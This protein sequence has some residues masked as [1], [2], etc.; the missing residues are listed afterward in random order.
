MDPYIRRLA[1]APIAPKSLLYTS[2]RW[3]ARLSLLFIKVTHRYRSR[4]DEP[5]ENSETQDQLHRRTEEVIDL[6]EVVNFEEADHGEGFGNAE[7]GVTDVGK[8]MSE[9]V[10]IDEWPLD[11]LGLFGGCKGEDQ[12]LALTQISGCKHRDQFQ[13]KDLEILCCNGCGL[14]LKPTVLS[15]DPYSEIHARGESAVS[16][17][18][19]LNFDIKSG[20]YV[21]ARF[22]VDR[23]YLVRVLR[24]NPGSFTDFLSGDFDVVDLATRP[25]YD[26]VS[27]TWANKDADD[28]RAEAIYIGPSNEALPITRNCAAALR[29]LR[30]YDRVRFLWVYAVC[31]DQNHVTERN[32]QVR[33][34]RLIF[35][36]AQHINIFLGN[37]YPKEEAV[38][39]NFGT[40][41]SRTIS[42]E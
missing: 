16:W 1:S 10:T 3:K 21:H 22:P 11:I 9:H 34:M 30:R 2:A 31:I 18:K 38:I 4:R 26:A 17:G 27:Y 36:S 33:Q 12:N 13:L 15:R 39:A 35:R 20:I 8:A 7:E 28:E 19:D 40:V 6:E 32:H 29:R 14:V 42:Y 41:L 25:V 37:D 24:L 5:R 23:G